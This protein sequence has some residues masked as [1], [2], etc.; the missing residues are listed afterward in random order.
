M[1]HP[2]GGYAMVYALGL[3]RQDTGIGKCFDSS[4]IPCD[5]ATSV[6]TIGRRNL[7]GRPAHI[8]IRHAR[9]P[10]REGVSRVF[11]IS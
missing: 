4:P 10:S 11:P 2:L 3:L 9:H 8:I 5:I 7:V 1:V 6:N